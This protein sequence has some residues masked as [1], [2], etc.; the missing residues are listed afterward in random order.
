[1]ELTTMAYPDQSLNILQSIHS[2][3]HERRRNRR[4]FVD[5]TILIRHGADGKL[6]TASLLDKSIGGFRA[7]YPGTPLAN[8]EQVL[9]MTPFADF[10]CEVVWTKTFEASSESGFKVLGAVSTKQFRSPLT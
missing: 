5:G 6:L 2:W 1:L 8:G 9:L 4:E 7:S 3:I 10:Q